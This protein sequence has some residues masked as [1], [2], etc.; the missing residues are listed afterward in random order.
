[1][2]IDL[3]ILGLVLLFAVVGA[4]SGGAKQIA[5][6]AAL[7]V[8]WFVSRKLGTYVG[9][10]MAEAL[11][12]APLL[13]GTVAG[14]LLLFIG[15]LVAVRYA[16]TT[17]LQRLFGSTNPEKRGLDGAI[18]FVLGGARVV[19]ITYVV[20]SALVF[21][22]QYIIVAGK[23]M[24]VSPK[25]SLSFA[26]ARRYNLFEMTQFAAV[27]DMVVVGKVASNP[28]RARRLAENPAYKSL[29]QDPRFQ[30]AMSDKQLREAME[31]GDTQ[32]VLRSNLVLQLLQDPEFAA[33]LGAAAR[34]SERE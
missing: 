28:E 18:G 19:A 9:P 33:R 4:I 20:L 31:R 27:K 29:K 23:R 15:V 10:K 11:G 5:N 14:S 25:D 34:A 6:M 17:L 7:A 12:G 21:A 2:T 22:E 3:I 32:A 26:L 16:L 1:M 13:I 8:A 24:G 30:R